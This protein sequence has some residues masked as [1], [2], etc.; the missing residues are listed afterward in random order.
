MKYIVERAK[1]LL[2]QV[3]NPFPATVRIAFLCTSDE[4]IG[5]SSSQALVE[6]EAKDSFCV[7]VTEPP[8]AG[9]GT[10]KTERKGSARLFFL[11]GTASLVTI[12]ILFSIVSVYNLNIWDAIIVGVVE[13]AES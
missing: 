3:L 5:S 6:K 2:Q 1:V 13:E 11:G 12:L 9:S 4:E 7:L 8:A 10:L